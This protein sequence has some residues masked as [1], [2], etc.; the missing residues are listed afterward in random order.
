LSL[1][2]ACCHPHRCRHIP[3]RRILLPVA[4]LPSSP[5]LPPIATRVLAH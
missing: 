1:V 5:L 2:V 3:L 4:P